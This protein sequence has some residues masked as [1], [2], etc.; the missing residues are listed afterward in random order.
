VI[1]IDHHQVEE[2]RHRR[3]RAAEKASFVTIIFCTSIFIPYDVQYVDR[4][5]SER[6]N[7]IQLSEP[8]QPTRRSNF[9]SLLLVV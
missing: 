4:V 9:T 7:I 8:N 5:E 1:N 2:Y 3:K 6:T